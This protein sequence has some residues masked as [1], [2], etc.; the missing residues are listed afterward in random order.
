[1]IHKIL[2]L[3]VGDRILISQYTLRRND[4]DDGDDDRE[5]EDDFDRTYGEEGRDDQPFRFRIEKIGDRETTFIDVDI[6]NEGD[7]GFSIEISGA[8]QFQY[9]S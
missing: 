2:D 3:E 5:G 1:M 6:E 8:H 4:D 7:K 9:Y